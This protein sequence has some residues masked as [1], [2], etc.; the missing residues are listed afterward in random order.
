M[1]LLAKPS[2]VKTTVLWICRLLLGGT[3]VYAAVLKVMD[4]PSFVVDIGHYHLLPYPLTVVLAIYLPWL[5]LVCGGAALFRWHERGALILLLGLC[6]LF[7]LALASAWFRDLD[8]SCGC[9]G[10]GTSTTLPLALARSLILGLVTVCLL[11]NHPSPPVRQIRVTS[12]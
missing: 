2:S 11:F 10:H 3:F 6:V 9:F 1:D 12:A 5:E 4:P 7:S 8:I